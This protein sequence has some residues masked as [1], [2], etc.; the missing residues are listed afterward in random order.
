M[1]IDQGPISLDQKYTQ[2][3]GHIFTT[4]LQALVRLPMAQIRRDRAAGLNTA[5]FISGYR[6]SPLGGYDQ[7]LFAAR[8][9]LERYNIKFQPGVNEDL[10]A[11]AVWGSQQLHLSPGAAYDGVVGIWYG[12]GPGVDRCGD[13]FRHGN[14]AGSARHGGVLCLAGDD[15]GAKSST[16]PHQSDHAFIAA[17]MPYLYPSSIH[18]MIQMGLLGIAMSRYSG[19]W[20]GMKVITETVETTAEIDL[21]DELTP[22]VTPSDFEMPPGG[23]N[24]RWPDDRYD[25]DR[26]LQDHKGFAAVAFARAN[27]I[28]RITMDSPNARF[29]IMASGKSYEDIRQALRELGIT[30]QVA[31][32]IGLRLYKIGMPW[33]LEPQGVREFAVGLEEIFIVEERREIVENQV[34]QELFNWR[35]DVRPRIIGKM[36]DHDKRFLPFAQELSV[37]SLATS[38][39]ERLLRLNLNPEIA[40]MLR[41]RAD[42]F[43]G[44]QATQMQ[45]A[46]P[47]AR[48]PYFCSGCPHNTSTRVPEGSRATAGIGCHY[49]AIWMDRNTE[50]FTHMGGEG[51]PWV[52][53]AP[54]TNEKHIF[55]NLGDGTYFHSGSLAIRQAV[56]SKANITYKILY[57][58][59]VAMTGGQHV[60]GDLSP[61]RITFQLHAEGVRDIYLV[62]E[63]PDAY[64]A[65]DIAPGSRTA[66]RDDLD[67]VMKT[68]RETKG[69]SAIVFVQT[70]AAEKRRRRKRGTMEDPQRRVLIN[71]AVC[72]GCG[73][74]SVQ[75]NCISVEPLETEMGRK[76]TINQSSCNK[77]YSCLKGFCPS[78]V[79]VDGGRLRQRA[80]A[81]LGAIG[82]LPE[83]P[84]RPSLERPYN[85]AVGGVGGTGVLTIG[86]LLG[87]AAHIEGKA[88]MIL[89]MSGLAQKGGAVLSHV[90]L[91]RN[92]A[93]VTCSRIVTGTADLVIAA[94]E[95]VAAA[96]DTMM[97]CASDRTHGVINTHLIPTADFVLNRDFDFQSGKVG[98]ALETALCKDATFMDFTTPAESLL[99]DSIATNMMMMG[100]AYQKGLLPLTAEAI[101]QAIEVNGVAV[102]MN[103][104]AFRLGRLAVV[105]PARLAEMMKGTDEPK[106]AKTLEQMTLD[107]IVA[108]RSAYLADYQNKRL[109][110][111]YR[112]MV[113]RVRSATARGGY[114]DALPRAVAVNYAKLLA[115]KDEYEV[116]RLYTDGRF[117]K[118]LGDQ[119]EGDYR[120]SFHLAPPMFDNKKDA[121]DRPVKRSYNGSRMMPLFRLLASMKGL[122]GTAFDMFGYSAARKL[123]RELIASYEKDVAF[124]LD[125]LSPANIES[126]IELLSLPDRIR[127]YG[128]VKEKAVASAKIR[129]SELARD[130]TDTP[131]APR[132]IAAE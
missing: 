126:A 118:Q 23:L 102:K 64:P 36:D 67:M 84:S 15:H 86:A 17:L 93:D 63:N 130:L 104:E 1:G 49:M 81:D 85:I 4:G 108:H 91:S 45:A 9:H 30:E 77:D 39:T 120:I 113:D 19:C 51:A 55:A 122:R 61:Q 73:D 105:N 87:M 38:L 27:R 79:T 132:Q 6:G 111:K 92:P 56:A 24:L 16:V 131:P 34:K 90:R 95:V 114:G 78:F 70:C 11:T 97:L 123:E 117:E 68:C 125:R 128:P 54:F 5:G 115:Y 66:H 98:R 116:A 48:V 74:C 94:D 109:A 89:D 2:G 50:T 80:P 3:T 32:R 107:E 26:R 112:V 37:A 41:A 62:S 106:A 110:E 40:E 20:V 14:A 119:F 71:P 35:D 129:H 101:E 28:N 21:A 22:F 10:A 8:S 42:W 75:S 43:N 65:A 121:L 25:Q 88:S 83:P 29:G 47:I 124:V 82:E 58:D 59:A 18:E 72:E 46:A 31:A 99:G 44:R 53:I 96:K 69:V 57:N 52:G 127:G 76:R 100:Y 33:P 13:V 12:K 103:I 7:Q 60:D